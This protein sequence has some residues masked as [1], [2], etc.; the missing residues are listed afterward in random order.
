VIKAA[1]QAGNNIKNL[2]FQELNRQQ[3]DVDKEMKNIDT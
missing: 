3:I 2:F 1:G